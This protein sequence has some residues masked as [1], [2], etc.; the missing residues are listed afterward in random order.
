MLVTRSARLDHH[1]VVTVQPTLISSSHSVSHYAHLPLRAI[2]IKYPH[3]I[4]PP[5]WLLVIGNHPI[6]YTY[7]AVAVV[8]G[9]SQG[10]PLSDIYPDHMNIV[11]A[12]AVR[13][14][15]LIS[16]ICFYPYYNY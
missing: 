9:E 10:Y 16:L 12:K 2:D 8:A 1:R 4:P 7:S 15:K 14:S 11:V 5:E 3:H 13:L 6:T